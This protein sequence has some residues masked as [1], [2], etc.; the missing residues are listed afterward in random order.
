MLE[1]IEL[2]NIDLNKIKLSEDTETSETQKILYEDIIKGF[3][4][5]HKKRSVLRIVYS[6]ANLQAKK[7]K[8]YGGENPEKL[9]IELLKKYPQYHLK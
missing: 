3:Y 6:T 8:N 9:K 5:F 2:N 4:D 7:T 1:F